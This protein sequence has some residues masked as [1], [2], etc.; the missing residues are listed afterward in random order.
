MPDFGFHDW[1]DAQLRN[2]PL[3]ANLL[4]RLA[5][6][7]P[8]TS[9]EDA[10]LDAALRNVPLPPGFEARLS[11]IARRSRGRQLALAA[12]VVVAAGLGLAGYATWM[13]Q[14]SGPAAGP[15]TMVAR[16]QTGPRAKSGAASRPLASR[17]ARAPK[18]AATAPAV[19][20]AST[21]SS[22]T[23]P[24]STVPSTTASTGTAPAATTDQIRPVQPPQPV[25]MR[26]L[27]GVEQITALGSSLR[28]A[29]EAKRRSQA[30]L[31]AGGALDRLPD[32]DVL[33]TLVS[34]RGVS[35]PRL[36]GYDLLFQLKHGEH[37]FVS[38]ARHP[39]LAVSR[40]PLTLD[41]ASYDLAWR[42]ARSG[43]L[44]TTDE[45]R[46]EDFLAAQHYLVPA[47]PRGG[48]SLLS[49]GSPSPLGSKGLYLLQWMVQAATRNALQHPPTRLVVAVEMSWQMRSG[50]RWEATQ[51]ALSHLVSEMNDADRLTLVGF[52]EQARTLAAE[53]H[54][55]EIKALLESDNFALPKGSADVAQAAQAVTEAIGAAGSTD[56]LRVVIITAKSHAASAKAVAA[57]QTL[58]PLSDRKIPWQIVCLTPAGAP[59]AGPDSVMHDWALAAGGKVASADCAAQVHDL[60]LESLMDRSSAVANGVSLKLTFS[61]RVVTGY[62]L[63]GHE[64][65][66]LTG[67][68]GDPLALDLHA[69]QMA[70]GLYEVWIKPT[71]DEVAVTAELTWRD[72]STNQPHRTVQ[73]L[74]R[75]QLAPSFSR[76]PAW[77]Q[78]GVVAAKA[79]EALRGSY[80]AMGPHPCAQVLEL[81]NQ[82]DP[83]VYKQRDFQDLLSLLHQ[84]EKGR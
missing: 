40:L 45:L 50:G 3:P 19:A 14:A 36:P 16:N 20:R 23:A 7:G 42:A 25:A 83:R 43:Q 61:P 54:G 81:A 38:P 62:R 15:V 82:V 44:S 70:T 31:G 2:V 21:A 27:P 51:R 12:S 69:D 13:G 84:A 80:Y 4:A 26:E 39:A 72:A 32:L 8:Q 11:R 76:A 55:P 48:L 53:A 46:I 33:D 24:S 28:Q 57:Q 66:T 56:H 71:G 35:P 10:R 18:P 29:A 49:A 1:L 22:I 47:A 65:V 73:S 6:N 64:A 58:A 75:S 34:R 52:G 79:A 77:F 67:P 68:A 30:A 41:T 37:P 59:S 78:Q 17:V 63:L 60:L 9:A 5:Q 74:R